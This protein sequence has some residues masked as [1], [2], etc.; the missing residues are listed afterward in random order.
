MNH[1]NIITKVKAIGNRGFV[2][3]TQWYCHQDRMG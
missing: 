3:E 1:K 2:N